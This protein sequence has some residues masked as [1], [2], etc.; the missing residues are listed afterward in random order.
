ML[1]N[2]LEGQS[3][4]GLE[5]DMPKVDMPKVDMPKVEM[6]KV[7]LPTC[8]EGDQG[9]DMTWERLILSFTSDL[10]DMTQLWNTDYQILNENATKFVHSLHRYVYGK[11]FSC[12]PQFMSLNSDLLCGCDYDIAYDSD[13]DDK[14][15]LSDSD[16]KEGKEKDKKGTHDWIDK[17]KEIIRNIQL[18]VNKNIEAWTL[19]DTFLFLCSVPGLISVVVQMARFCLQKKLKNLRI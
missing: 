8:L 3:G 17:V 19:K 9:Q 16:K 6:P 11:T 2:V 1:F 12:L 14:S 10:E 18:K 7:E 13:K 15:P 4:N 5:G